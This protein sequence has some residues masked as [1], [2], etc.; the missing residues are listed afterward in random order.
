MALALTAD[1]VAAE[2]T[3]R[4]SDGMFRA[5]PAT[6][7]VGPVVPARIADETP[8]PGVTRPTDSPSPSSPHPSRLLDDDWPATPA[9]SLRFWNPVFAA[10]PALPAW[11]PAAGPSSG[12][13]VGAVGDRFEV[14][15]AIGGGGVA[16]GPLAF[17]LLP[18][19]DPV[20]GANIR[21]L[22]FSGPGL[23]TVVADPGDGAFR[24]PPHWKRDAYPL[25]VGYTRGDTAAVSGVFDAVFASEQDLPLGAVLTPYKVQADGPGDYD[26][27]PT[28]V[29]LAGRQFDLPPTPLAEPFAQYVDYFSDFRLQWPFSYYS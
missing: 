27:P 5:V 26:L 28:E 9:F 3:S 10:A 21:E 13:P 14:P 20:C 16:L 22:T 1:G 19:E 15:V 24:A 6:E 7:W 4:P 8:A 29:T 17:G 18:V 11:G 25:P 12:P 23:I 2:P